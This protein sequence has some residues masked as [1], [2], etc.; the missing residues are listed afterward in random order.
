MKLILSAVPLNRPSSRPSI[1]LQPRAK[2]QAPN[3]PP[4]R[5]DKEPNKGGRQINPEIPQPL[6]LSSAT[7][8]GWLAGWRCL[9]IL[10]THPP[11]EPK[12]HQDEIIIPNLTPTIYFDA[13]TRPRRRLASPHSMDTANQLFAQLATLP[14]RALSCLPPARPPTP[15]PTPTPTVRAVRAESE[16]GKQPGRRTDAVGW[17]GMDVLLALRCAVWMD[18]WMDGW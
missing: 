12:N 11:A 10:P 1:S 7:C 5:S 13:Y 4:H 2:T 6:S 9:Q 18:G 3:P 16:C 17:S 15:T 8:A 14:C